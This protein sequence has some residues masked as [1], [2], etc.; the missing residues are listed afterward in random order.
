MRIPTFEEFV[1]ER[2]F[3]PSIDRIKNGESRKEDII[4][5]Q[6]KEELKRIIENTI[7][8]KNDFVDLNFIDVADITDMSRLFYELHSKL[9]NFD[10]SKWDVSNV[11]D[12]SFMFE[13]CYDFNCDLS[14]W[15]VSNVN[16]MQQM[17]A[18][19]ESFNS[20]ISKWDVSNVKDMRMMFYECKNFNCDLSKWNISDDTDIEKIFSY[21]NKL[22]PPKWYYDR[23]DFPEWARKKKN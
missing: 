1:N 15:D 19:C 17:F 3:K 7:K 21:C 10:I 6:T 4:R 22:E 5:P 13:M 20:D 12:M 8:D 23:L 11:K 14:E 18:S 16:S 2:L 9:T